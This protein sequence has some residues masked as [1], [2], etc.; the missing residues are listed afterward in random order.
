[1]RA[2]TN[3]GWR[4]RG[5]PELLLGLVVI[6][7]AFVV[8]GFVVADAIRDVKQSRDTIKV[9]VLRDTRSPPIASSGTWPLT[10]RRSSPRRQR[11]CCARVPR[12]FA[13]SSGTAASRT[14]PSRHPR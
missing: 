7:I 6:A 5:L 2:V 3:S 8:T 13:T 9:T 4:D 12:P 11:D 14:L 10:R 1:M